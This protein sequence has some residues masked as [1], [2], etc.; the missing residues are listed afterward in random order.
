[1][2]QATTT[3]KRFLLI[4]FSSLG[5]VVLQ[6]SIANYLRA[7]YPDCHISFLTSAEFTSVLKEH[8]SIDQVISYDRS[9]KK[10]KLYKEFLKKLK[11][12]NHFDMIIDLH[13]NTRTWLLKRFFNNVPA[14]S[15]DK[16]NLK[17][18][19]LVLFKW[20]LL[21]REENTQ[22]E[23]NLLK[24]SNFLGESKTSKTRPLTSLKF[25][26][27]TYEVPIKEDFVVIC[28]V[29]SFKNKR[30]PIEYYRELAELILQHTA[31]SVVCLAGPQDNYVDKLSVVSQ[32]HPSRFHF[33]KGKL[34]LIETQPYLKAAKVVV[35]NDSG[36]NHMSEA[37][38]T[39]VIT[40]FGPTHEDFGFRP[41]LEQSIAISEN[42]W[43]RP[44][45]TKG[46]T[47]C[48]RPVP[49]CMYNIKPDRIYQYVDQYL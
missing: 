45:S 16:Y 8:S 22:I 21:K 29:A 36:L 7:L 31:L 11:E 18:R 23:R 4:R 38:G 42:I 32:N 26:Y 37:L 27:Q 17:R 20:N 28:P 44:C 35:G 43:C 12:N 41:H 1:M 14:F 47:K 34:N 49:Y 5:D 46:N 10:Y 40:I 15:I 13:R 25:S 24:L 39:P 3:A 19:L 30:W 48:I 9:Q 33:M 6:T 2:S